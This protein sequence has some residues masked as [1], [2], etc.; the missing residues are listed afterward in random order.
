MNDSE[1]QATG[2]PRVPE[3]FLDG[4]ASMQELLTF[5]QSIDPKDIPMGD[6]VKLTDWIGKLADALNIPE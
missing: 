6:Y 5:L 4:T 2:I 3:R 1:R